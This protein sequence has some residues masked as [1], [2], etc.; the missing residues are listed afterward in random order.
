MNIAREYLNAVTGILK[1]NVEKEQANVDRAARLVAR[2]AVCFAMN[3]IMARSVE[4]L[5]ERDRKPP[6]WTSA[7]VRGGDEANLRYLQEYRHRVHHLYPMF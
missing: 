4:I 6:V 3:L 5:I 1:A 2:T 7:N